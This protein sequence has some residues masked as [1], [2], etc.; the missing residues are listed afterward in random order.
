MEYLYFSVVNFGKNDSNSIKMQLNDVT[1][2]DETEWIMTG[3]S[4]GRIGIF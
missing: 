1:L 4:L 2:G 3:I